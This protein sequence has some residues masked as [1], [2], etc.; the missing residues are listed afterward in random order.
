MTSDRLSS[1]ET[2]TLTLST[3]SDGRPPQHRRYLRLWEAIQKTRRELNDWQSRVDRVM[4]QFNVQIRPR[5]VKLTQEVQSGTGILIDHA[6]R[7][8]LDQSQAALLHLWIVDNLESLAHHPFADKSTTNALQKRWHQYV[9]ADSNKP[10]NST[11]DHLDPLDRVDDELESLI[12]V[13]A[14]RPLLTNATVIVIKTNPI[15]DTPIVNL[16]KP[17]IHRRRMMMLN[18]S[19]V[20]TQVTP[21]ARVNRSLVTY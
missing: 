8:L 10:Q 14:T 15:K 21:Q 1:R 4:S 2:G 16:M 11:E 9:Y 20:A 5:E 13:P 7:T 3:K 17:V 18:M 6:Y 19:Q 12:S